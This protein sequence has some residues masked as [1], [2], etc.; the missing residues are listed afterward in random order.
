MTLAHRHIRQR[1][2]LQFLPL[3]E[4]DGTSVIRGKC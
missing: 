2:P 3:A 1:D 4:V